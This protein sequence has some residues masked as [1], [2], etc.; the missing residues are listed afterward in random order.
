[1]GFCDGAMGCRQEDGRGKLEEEDGGSWRKK[2][3]GGKEVEERRKR[4]DGQV[5]LMARLKNGKVRSGKEWRKRN[6]KVTAEVE[7]CKQATTSGRKN[8]TY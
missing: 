2:G 1:M 6:G 8:R 7:R 4:L 3:D 5:A